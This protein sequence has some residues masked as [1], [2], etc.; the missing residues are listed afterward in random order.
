[1]L[2]SCAWLA[3]LAYFLGFFRCTWQRSA[4][5]DR[6]DRVGGALCSLPFQLPSTVTWL[7]RMATRERCSEGPGCQPVGKLSAARCPRL[8][9]TLGDPCWRLSTSLLLMHHAYVRSM[10]H[11]QTPALL[12]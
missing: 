8:P 3:I 11:A 7:A 6:V 1:M 9:A 4:D 12:L 5:L 2:L 10:H